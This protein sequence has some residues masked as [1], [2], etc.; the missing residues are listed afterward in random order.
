MKQAENLPN[1]AY[2]SKGIG[3][4]HFFDMGNG[5]NRD[6]TLLPESINFFMPVNGSVKFVTKTQHIYKY[7]RIYLHLYKRISHSVPTN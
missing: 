6:S 3:Q 4:A 1:G 5:E 7:Y 2:F